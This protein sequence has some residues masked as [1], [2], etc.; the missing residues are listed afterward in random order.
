[1][2]KKTGVVRK[3]RTLVHGTKD[4]DQVVSK[5]YG[6]GEAV[7][8]DA[9]EYD[10]LLNAGVIARKGSEQA[11]VAKATADQLPADFPGIEALRKAEI[12]TFSALE[13]VD[14]LTDIKGIGEA[15]AAEISE[16]LGARA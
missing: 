3:G 14:D 11:Q 7:E 2:A 13:E 5:S 6:P 10:R 12:T 16:A 4:G 15:T 9:K 8:L 1:M